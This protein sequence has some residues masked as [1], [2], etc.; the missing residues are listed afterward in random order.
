MNQQEKNLLCARI[1]A[2]V[3]AFSKAHKINLKCEITKID[4]WVTQ[5]T[6]D[7][8]VRVDEVGESK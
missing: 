2:A 7:F 4:E 6:L 1:K 5:K 3:L 8:N